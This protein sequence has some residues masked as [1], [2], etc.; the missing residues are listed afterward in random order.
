MEGGG[1][2]VE[3]GGWR[4]E[5]G[6]LRIDRAQRVAFRQ[7]GAHR[8]PTTLHSHTVD[9]APFIKSQLASRI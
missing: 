5:G 3:G 4:V 9:Y 6:E 2:R 7:R 1:L 8:L